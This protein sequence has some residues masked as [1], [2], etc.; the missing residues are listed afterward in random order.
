ML[1]HYITQG[2]G[3]LDSGKLPELLELRY[4]SMRDAV[5]ELGSVGKIREM[6]VGFQADLYGSL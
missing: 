3:E 1:D 5:D 6:F 2:V 4:H